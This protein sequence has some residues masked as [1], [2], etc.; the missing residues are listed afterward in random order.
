VRNASSRSK[1]VVSRLRTSIPTA[2]TGND[3]RDSST[4]SAGK[5]Y[6]TSVIARSGSAK[7][8]YAS[9]ASS[10]CFGDATTAGSSMSIIVAPAAFNPAISLAVASATASTRSSMELKWSS[11]EASV[12]N[13]SGPG[14]VADLAAVVTMQGTPQLLPVEALAD[15][16]IR[17]D[18]RGLQRHAGTLASGLGRSPAAST[19]RA[20]ASG[21]SIAYRCTPRTP[22]SALSALTI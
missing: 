16:W 10:M 18:D 12:A 13:V 15:L 14:T 17:A 2:A 9:R 20:T 8:P 19:T 5:K 21:H 1:A 11:L 3:A 6:V 7:R 4:A 22:G